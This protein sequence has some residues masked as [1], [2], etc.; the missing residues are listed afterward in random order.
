[1][2]LWCKKHKRVVTKDEAE[3][4]CLFENNHK[5][6]VNLTKKRRR[7]KTFGPK[8]L[9]QPNK[10]EVPAEKKEEILVEK[11]TL[12]R[13]EYALYQ[14]GLLPNNHK[15]GEGT[16]LRKA[17]DDQWELFQCLMSVQAKVGL[18]LRSGSIV[19]GLLYKMLGQQFKKL[20]VKIGESEDGH[21]IGIFMDTWPRQVVATRFDLATD[22][23][24]LGFEPYLEK[25]MGSYYDTSW[26]DLDEIEGDLF[27]DVY[28]VLSYLFHGKYCVEKIGIVLINGM[29][30]TGRLELVSNDRALLSLGSAGE[31]QTYLD[32]P[33][34]MISTVRFEVGAKGWPHA[35][36]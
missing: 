6:C 27:W 28:D 12:E 2:K 24:G 14:A 11:K 5:G 25:Q 13:M 1:M 16:V 7:K 17:I 15:T 30:F 33:L 18:I 22:F 20:R 8:P 34:M 23:K 26:Q 35:P 21:G 4:R 29:E 36:D 32:V 3:R 31:I 9:R 10:E 19:E